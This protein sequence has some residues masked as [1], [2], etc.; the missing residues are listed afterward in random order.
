MCSGAN[1]IVSKLGALVVLDSILGRDIDLDSIP[2]QP[3]AFGVV[4]GGSIDLAG[5][6]IRRQAVTDRVNVADQGPDS[7]EEAEREAALAQLMSG[8]D[9]VGDGAVF[10]LADGGGFVR[11]A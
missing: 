6:G 9:L 5:A 7:D 10:R 3:L 1:T 11:G 4:P 2:L 8:E